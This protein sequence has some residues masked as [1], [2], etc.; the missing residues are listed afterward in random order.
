M[1]AAVNPDQ[2]RKLA[3]AG[4][5]RAPEVRGDDAAIG[6]TGAANL[7]VAGDP[8][9]FKVEGQFQVPLLG[10]LDGES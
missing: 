4:V 8:L 9:G 2:G 10:G 7:S 1:Y 5:E 6:R 3:V